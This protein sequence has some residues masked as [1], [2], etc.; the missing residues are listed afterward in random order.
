LSLKTN[1][2]RE[3]MKKLVEDQISKGNASQGKDAKSYYVQVSLS[4]VEVA[5]IV[6][7][8]VMIKGTQTIRNIIRWN[9]LVDAN[10]N[11]AFF[12]GI[13]S[14]KESDAFVEMKRGKAVEEGGI[15]EPTSKKKVT[16]K[17]EAPLK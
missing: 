17:K 16:W 4:N 11:R 14:K 5:S 10:S 7:N 15:G 8:E 6:S 2:G 1:F 9:D 13:E 12:G 3:G